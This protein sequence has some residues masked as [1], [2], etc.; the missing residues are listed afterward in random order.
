MKYQNTT[1]K[2]AVDRT[3]PVFADLVMIAAYVVLADV[4][5]YVL[6]AG[7]VL[8]KVITIPLLCF[9]PGYAVVSALYPRRP[10]AG[11]SNAGTERGREWL[12]GDSAGW[13]V[14]GLLSVPLSVCVLSVLG[15]ALS[16]LGFSLASQWV[17]LA[18]LETVVIAALT[19]GLVRRLWVTPSE[20]FRVPYRRP[21][22][23]FADALSSPSWPERALNLTLVV[24]VLLSIGGLA[25]GLTAYSSAER[26]TTMTLV[27]ENESGEYVAGDFPSN[28]S[29]GEEA[30]LV[31]N[32]ENHEGASAEY[33]VVPVVQR[34]ATDNGSAVVVERRQF[35]P[36]NLAVDRGESVYER[37]T[38]EARLT[39]SNVR[40][41]YL[42]YR[43][44]PPD[45]PTVD[46]AYRYVHVWLNASASGVPATEQV[47]PPEPSGDAVS[48][49]ITEF[50]ARYR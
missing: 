34:V 18:A 11:L 24:L 9:V 3:L 15:V 17:P 42:L 10:D 6:P 39:G 31:V 13:K 43:G 50:D 36:F 46:S 23:R 33:S 37:H 12:L 22:T 27:T 38:F 40:I 16:L 19:V 41:V 21:A 29:S 32:V 25:Y 35:D 7:S 1:E 20:R 14:R 26:Y 47:Q 4:L 2:V 44:A 49:A 45:N 30:S 48:P 28:L 8:R 5:V